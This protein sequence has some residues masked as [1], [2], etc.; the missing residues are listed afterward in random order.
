ML[1]T[2]HVAAL[3]TT[4][5]TTPAPLAVSPSVR[6]AGG[7]D[8]PALVALINRAHLDDA[9]FVDGERTG[10][11][12]VEALM[13]TGH[14]LVLDRAPR[15]EAGLAAAVFVQVGG[16]RSA[17][18][19]LAVAPDLR[20]RGL[21]RRLVGV[22]EALGQALGARVMD[23]ETVSLREDLPPWYR[24]MGYRDTGTAPLAQPSRRPCH[25]IMMSK[26]LA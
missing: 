20:G 9:A 12:Q 7:A 11:A 25:L 18:T 3:A 2:P 21:G 16:A 10:A 15:G 23:L 14:F 24:R 8:V 26:P 6:L 4:H 1:A 17:F 13:T 5:A 19:M 22:A